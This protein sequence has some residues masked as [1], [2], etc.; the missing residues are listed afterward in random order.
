V[1]SFL[2]VSAEMQLIIACVIL[3]TASCAQCNV[4]FFL[5][6]KTTEV[7]SELGN[8]ICPDS[9]ECPDLT[10]CCQLTT[11]KY[12]CCPLPSVS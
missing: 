10:T 1:F 8:I 7:E 6:K 4:L 5:P 11:G 12:G 3:F 2:F 9:G